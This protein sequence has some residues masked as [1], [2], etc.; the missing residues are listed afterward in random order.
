MK[1][2]SIFKNKEA[3]HPWQWHSCKQQPKTHSFRADDEIFKTVN[4][5]F[6]DP[7]SRVGT[8]KSCSTY[9]GDDPGGESVEMIIRGV[10]SERLIFEPSNTSSSILDEAKMSGVLPLK[11]SIVLA[12]ESDDPYM[13]FKKS[14]EEMVETHGLKDWECLEELLAWYLRMNER[15]NQGFIVGAFID[16]LKGLASSCSNSTNSRSTAIS[17]LLGDFPASEIAAG[18]PAAEILLL[19]ATISLSGKRFPGSDFAAF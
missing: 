6:S 7:S 3:K 8:P 13:D 15:T 5:V 1:I 14:M 11:E 19:G 2:P 18:F 10:Q 17:L 4:S 9:S 12:I 16:L